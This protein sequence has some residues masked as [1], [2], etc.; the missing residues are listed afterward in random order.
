MMMKTTCTTFSF[1]CS[2]ILL[3]NSADSLRSLGTLNGIGTTVSAL[4]RAIG[5]FIIGGVFTWG[6]KHNSVLAPYALLAVSAAANIIPVFLLEEGKGFGDEAVDD[7][8]DM[9]S[10]GRVRDL[11]ES[12]LITEE[13]DEDAEESDFGVMSPLLSRTSTLSYAGRSVALET[14]DELGVGDVRP[15]H[16]H[17]LSAN[18]GSRRSSRSAPRQIVRRRT[19]VPVG[20]GG[21]FRKF[22]AN[23]GQSLSGYGTGGGPL[24]G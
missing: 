6:V 8:V 3:T 22:S 23:L 11:Q 19:S 21:G 4:G 5:P 17:S 15:E 2:T 24:G 13:V 20:M 14:D 1:P 9:E 12:S 16:H 7:S 10:N 18:L